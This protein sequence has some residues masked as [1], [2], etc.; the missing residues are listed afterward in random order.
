MNKFSCHLCINLLLI[1]SSCAFG[2]GIIEIALRAYGIEGSGPRIATRLKINDF[3]SEL[4]WWPRAARSY[5]RSDPYYGH[6][7]YYNAARMP[8]APGLV[9]VSPD[10]EAATIAFIGDSFVEG[11]YV[12]YEKSFVHLVDLEF[13]NYQVINL[14]VSGYNPSQYL[15][16][17]R[18]DLPKYNVRYVIVGFFAYNDVQNVDHP[19]MQGYARP[20]FSDDLRAPLNTPVARKTGDAPEVSL[21]H[22]IARKSAAYSVIRPFYKRAIRYIRPEVG[23]APDQDRLNPDPRE[24]A[25]ALRLI[26]AIQ[27]VVPEAILI[28]V[29]IPFYE[30]LVFPNK[31]AID[32]GLF[33]SNCS[34]L[35][36][37]CHVPRFIENPVETL[38]PLYIGSKATEGHFSELGSK[39]FAEF[40]IE[41]LYR[42]SGQN[43]N[44][45]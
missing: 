41:V 22:R 12:P 30:Q 33:R 25:K 28:V 18:M 14:G 5:Y 35:Q 36:I 39:M 38:E 16:R 32:L 7:N 1:V 44:R 4:G 45:L 34:A 9:D 6:F 21:L 23:D 42:R 15:L 3:H 31:L 13:D 10:P 19:Y 11:Y 27:E 17:A 8:V 20:V 24:Y 37:G 29:Y 43:N 2:L 26:A 40:I